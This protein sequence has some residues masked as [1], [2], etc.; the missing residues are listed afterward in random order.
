MT[1][2][3]Q[4]RKALAQIRKIVESLG[5]D[6]Y[7]GTA[8]DGCFEDAEENIENDFAMSY[9]DR[10]ERRDMEA[11]RLEKEIVGL[12]NELELAKKTIKDEVESKNRIKENAGASIKMLEEKLNK[13]QNEAFD[14]HKNVYIELAN[15]DKVSK[16]F[17]EIKYINH[18]GF[19][20]VNVVE[21]SGWTTSYKMEDIKSI[22]IA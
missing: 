9:K 2:K 5:E 14:E 13:A 3:E 19:T 17:A 21:K 6:S 20:F 1:T 10:Y 4:E 18:N 7:V 16:P 22:R 11:D 15:G 8:F 12:K